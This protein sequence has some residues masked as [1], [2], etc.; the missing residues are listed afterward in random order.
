[1]TLKQYHSKLTKSL[2]SFFTD[3]HANLRCVF[4]FFQIFAQTKKVSVQ[5][6]EVDIGF[7]SVLTFFYD[8]LH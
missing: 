8:I 6:S 3:A 5:H 1:M 7:Q 2:M 4:I